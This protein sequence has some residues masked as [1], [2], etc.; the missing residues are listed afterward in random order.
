MK[1]NVQKEELQN[2][3]NILDVTVPP[4]LERTV[5]TGVEFFDDAVGGE[6]MTPSSV[7]LLSGTPGAGKTTLALQIADSLTGLG[8]LACFMSGE[9]CMYQTRKVTK[10]LKFKH[11]FVP[12]QES[13]VDSLL[14][15][16][17]RRWT[18]EP[19][20]QLFII[21]DSLQALDDGS[22][23][24]ND[25]AQLRAL[26]RITD[27]CKDTFAIAIVICQVTKSGVFAGKNKCV[28]AVDVH[29]HFYLDESTKSET[30]GERLFE[31]RKNRWGVN[32]RCYVV[33][34]GEEGVFEKGSFQ[35][36]ALSGK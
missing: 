6:G 16:V 17:A 7:M 9:E 26:E 15:F 21:Y 23:A 8:H 28:H 27:F 10:R 34:V 32:G 25:T 1:L 29:G 20:K 4:Q 30:F 12:G 11:G 13:N 14:G 33:G 36:I 18:Q 22:N 35:R 5:R 24:F 3:K 2:V 31:V 19:D